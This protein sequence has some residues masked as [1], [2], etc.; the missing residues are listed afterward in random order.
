ML[1]PNASRLSY[2]LVVMSFSF[3]FVVKSRANGKQVK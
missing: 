1:E 2:S 3:S